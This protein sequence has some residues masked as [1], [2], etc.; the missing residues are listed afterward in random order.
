[1]NKIK[2]NDTVKVMAGRDKGKTGRVLAVYPETGRALVEGVN[3]VK[4]HA[5]R[6]QQDQQGGIVSKE[7]PLKISKVMFLC[8]SCGKPTRV[9]LT[10]LGDG[11]KARQC[12]RCGETA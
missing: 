9:G 6:T 7:S 4:K 10:M 11:T 1:M 3:F 12:K 8:K 2:K 5:R